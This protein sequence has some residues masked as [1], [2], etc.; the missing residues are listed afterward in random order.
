M[1]PPIAGLLFL[2]AASL[3]VSAFFAG[4][5]TALVSLS[6]IELQAMLEKG[7]ARAGRVQK[8]KE[9]PARMLATILVVQN[10]CNSAASA[11]ATAIA[12]ALLGDRA[13]IGVATVAVTVLIFVFGEVLP[14]S[15]ATGAPAAASR[16]VALPVSFAT[17]LFSPFVNVV[18][19]AASRLLRAV[20]VPE[21]RP[22]FTEEEMKSVINL[23]HDAGVIHSEEK[24][25]LHNVLAFGD[26]TA[27]DLMIPR[28]KIVALP[29]SAGFEDVRYL[30]HLHKVSRLPVYRGTLDNVIGI[31]HAKDLY[32]LADEE[33]RSFSVPGHVRPP[34]LVPEFKRAEELFREM[35]RRRTHMA[36]VVDEYG[37][38]AGVV[39]IEDVIEALLGSIEDEY[40]EVSPGIVAAGERTYLVEGTQRL[41]D[42]RERFGLRLAAE[43]VETIAGYI[44]YRLGRVPR[45]GERVRSRGAEFIVEEATPTAVKKVKMVL[46]QPAMSSQPAASSSS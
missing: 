24:R 25:L 11:L 8:L 21:G 26:K 16:F 37:G 12:I 19:A 6:R 32:D 31:L 20:G 35:R 46:Q 18:T 43:G 23:G 2:L 4:A 15:V 41:E 13:G 22:A 40:A 39:T 27:Q 1:N 5:E 33:E 44:E 29:E 28:T 34:Y 30:L 36:I 14:K 17:H 45:K 7:V 9:T 3:S 38:T 42:L 10:L